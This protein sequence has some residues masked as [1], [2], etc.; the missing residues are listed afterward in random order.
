MPIARLFIASLFTVLIVG[1]GT[2]CNEQGS[3]DIGQTEEGTLRLGSVEAVDTVSRAVAPNNRPLVLNSFRG[4][5]HLT[6]DGGETAELTFIRRGRGEDVEAARSVLGD[7]SLTEEGTSD[8]YTF[9][10]DAEGDAYAA[11]DVRGTVPRSTDLRIERL[12][13]P[14]RI[15][16]VEGD[17][18]IQHD[19]GPVNVRGAASP[20]EVNIDNGDVRV[21]FQAVPAEGTVSLRTTNGDVQV[22]LPPDA[23]VRLDARTSVGSIQTQGLTLTDEQFTPLSAGGRY[24]ASLGGG[25][26]TVELRTENGTITIQAADTTRRDTTQQSPSTDTIPVPPSDT[27]VTPPSPDTTDTAATDPSPIPDTVL[28]DTTGP[29]NR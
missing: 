22:S 17:L 27:V 21:D 4:T 25:G 26:P 1:V 18:S 19:D 28:S 20:V 7:I 16:G 6:G 15:E 29:A 23:S 8:A 13:G 12:S 24:S 3:S 11:V 9:T 10:L 5:V 2:A 14:V